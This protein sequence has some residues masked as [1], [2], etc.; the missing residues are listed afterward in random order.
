MA[1]IATALAFGVCCTIVC[2]SAISRIIYAMARDRQ[3]PHVL[4]RVHPITKQPYVANIMVALVSLAIALWFQDH[5]AELFLFQN[6]GALCA[7]TLVNISMISY[8][9]FK[10]GSRRVISHLVCPAIGGAI[11]LTLLASM[12]AATL[13]LG[14][15]WIGLGVVYYLAMRYGL[16]RS[17]ALEV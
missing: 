8:F 15:A 6:F 5:L 10:S 1:S 7:F 3:L 9:W 16:G 17:V 12:R 4:A 2:Q 13:E 14:G 11:T